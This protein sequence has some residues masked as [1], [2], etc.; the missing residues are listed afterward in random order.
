[1]YNKIRHTIKPCIVDMCNVHNTNPLS[2]SLNLTILISFCVN[3]VV[4][5]KALNTIELV[6]YFLVLVGSVSKLEVLR[7][8]GIFFCC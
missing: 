5:S 8:Y 2:L 3:Q 4:N 1:M 6:P 7:L